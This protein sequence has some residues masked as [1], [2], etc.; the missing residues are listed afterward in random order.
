[1][2]LEIGNN[3]KY[4]RGL[5]LIYATEFYNKRNTRRHIKISDKRLPDISKKYLNDI[6]KSDLMLQNNLKY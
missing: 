5:K 4:M 6:L 1:M 2:T 3:V